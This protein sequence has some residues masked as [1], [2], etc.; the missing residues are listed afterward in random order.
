MQIGK[1]FGFY[2]ASFTIMILSVIT[3]GGCHNDNSSEMLL[4]AE[5]FLPLH[6]DS[7]DMLLAE[8]ENKG[9]ISKNDTALYFLLRAMTNM[10][11]QR[12]AD[13]NEISKAYEYYCNTSKSRNQ[14]D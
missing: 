13:C 11:Y 8:Y 3:F 1:K 2:I 14:L 7:A 4:R 6:T 9:Y 12:E 5:K 10:Y